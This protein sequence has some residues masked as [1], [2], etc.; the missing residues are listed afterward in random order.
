MEMTGCG[1]DYCFECV[2]NASF[3]QEA[4]A[5]CRMVSSLISNPEA[6][7]SVATNL[8]IMCF[9]FFFLLELQGWGKTIMLGADKPGAQVTLPSYNIVHHGKTLSASLFGGI[10]P[11]S[12]I[13]VL[14]KRYLDKVEITFISLFPFNFSVVLTTKTFFLVEV[15]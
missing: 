6:H 10:K 8:C 5:C 11:K 1:A 14:L 2:G 15:N 12:D 9:S 3:V 7:I 13:P 4:Y